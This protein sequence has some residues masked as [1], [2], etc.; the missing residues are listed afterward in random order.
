MKTVLNFFVEVR[1]EAQMV[2]WLSW[3]VTFQLV[4]LIL[5]F[6]VVFG[7]FFLGLDYLIV[8]V[9]SLLNYL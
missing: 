9:V 8:N 7:V 1:Q 5:F 3:K 2:N 4:L 6:I